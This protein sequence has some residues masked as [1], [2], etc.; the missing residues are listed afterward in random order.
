[1]SVP[2]L[3]INVAE[4]SD[5]EIAARLSEEEGVQVTPREVA[6]IQAQALR[7]LRKILL[8]RGLD[9]DSLSVVACLRHPLD[10]L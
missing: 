6:I 5:E 8:S 7:K 3:I 2:Q 1:M 10:R 4:A 9:Y